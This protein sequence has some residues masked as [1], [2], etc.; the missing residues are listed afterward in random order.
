[1]ISFFL[2]FGD[3]ESIFINEFLFSE[4]KKSD[5]PKCGQKE[6]GDEKVEITLLK[7]TKVRD[8]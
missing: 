1:M 3:L 8:K 7:K 2:F 4:N 6:N 5:F